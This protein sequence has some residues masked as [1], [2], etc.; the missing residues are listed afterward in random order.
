MSAST[1]CK[2]GIGP[3]ALS[4]TVRTSDQWPPTPPPIIDNQRNSAVWLIRPS[5]ESGTYVRKHEIGRPR[6]LWP[7]AGALERTGDA[8]INHLFET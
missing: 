2:K 8:N 3:G 7:S 4:E 5:I 6:S 1:V